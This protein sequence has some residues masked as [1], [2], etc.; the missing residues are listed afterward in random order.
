MLMGVLE[1]NSKQVLNMLRREGAR[2]TWNPADTPELN[3]T[4]EKKFRTLGERCLSML[5]H[6]G[7]PVDFW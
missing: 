3:A 1:S 7:M 2:Y 5:L 6:S 4:S